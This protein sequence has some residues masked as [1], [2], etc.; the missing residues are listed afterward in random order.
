[1]R[2]IHSKSILSPERMKKRLSVLAPT[3]ISWEKRGYRVI[4][5]DP[6]IPD[7]FAHS[8]V[9]SWK[10][11]PNGVK[12]RCIVFATVS[13]VAGP[14]FYDDGYMERRRNEESRK[15]R[16]IQQRFA[17]SHRFSRSLPLYERVPIMQSLCELDP[18]QLPRAWPQ[19]R[20]KFH[21]AMPDFSIALSE[22]FEF[23]KSSSREETS[24]SEASNAS[25]LSE[26]E[27]SFNAAVYLQMASYT[28][29]L[30]TETEKKLERERLM[31]EASARYEFLP[32]Y[33]SKCELSSCA[34]RDC[35]A[36]K[37]AERTVTDREREMN[38]LLGHSSAIFDAC[39]R[40]SDRCDPLEPRT[41]SSSV[42]ETYDNGES[43]LRPPLKHRE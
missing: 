15:R 17:Q 12:R 33:L 20:V 35:A 2:P 30:M 4:N 23:K 19:I 13:L 7:Y 40:E 22:G 21:T 6:S 8:I 37:Q 32:V 5:R 28:L 9:I 34:Q 41:D 38:E 29:A 27:R 39:M 18:I 1:M 14:P 31:T 10:T 36:P 43:K 25:A 3:R 24:N 26:P 16:F 11:D 42:T